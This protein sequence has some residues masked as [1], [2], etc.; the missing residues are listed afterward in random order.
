MKI[1]KE[2]FSRAFYS[3][4]ICFQVKATKQQEKKNRH[5]VNRKKKK[6]LTS[7]KID[8]CKT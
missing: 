6:K 1:K 5:R 7:P 4:K 8:K 2:K 3:R